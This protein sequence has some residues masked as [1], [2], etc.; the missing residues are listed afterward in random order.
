MGGSLNAARYAWSAALNE[1]GVERNR[2][3]AENAALRV[4][5]AE[6]LVSSDYNAKK[7]ARAALAKGGTL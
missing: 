4:A 7:R 3:R 1:G 5:L 6:L 2:L